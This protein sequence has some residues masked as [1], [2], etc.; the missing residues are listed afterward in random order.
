[1]TDADN[2]RAVNAQSDMLAYLQ[3]K[4]PMQEIE[5]RALKLGL[6]PEELKEN[7]DVLIE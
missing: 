7:Y 1:M 5:S 4:V 6:G 3:S 2:R